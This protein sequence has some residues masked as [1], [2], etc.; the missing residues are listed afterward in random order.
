MVD[1]SDT[2]GSIIDLCNE[3][4]NR[5]DSIADNLHFMRKVI[6]RGEGV[7]ALDRIDDLLNEI[8]ITQ[9]SIKSL[10]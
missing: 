9:L 8:C 7:A 5:V 3:T 4:L 10:F 1:T 2:V 6:V